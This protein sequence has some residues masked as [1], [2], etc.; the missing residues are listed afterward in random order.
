MHAGAERLVPVSLELGGKGAIVI[1][2]DV[3]LEA[4]VDWIMIGI[5]LC[6]GQSCSAT[7]RLVVHKG[8]SSKLLERLAEEARKLK[9]DD[10]L[11]ESTQLGPLTS[12]EQ[13][14]IVSGFVD[15]ARK[16]GCDVVCGGEM[17]CRKGYYYPATILQTPVESEAWKEEI[18][19]PV[20]A[21]QTCNDR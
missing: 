6:A 21:V 5:F 1:F 4:A 18:F 15:R 19:G 12:Q 14:D 11:L 7:S 16:E 20:L 17:P 9:M 8:I 13:L 3:D 10:P 2:D